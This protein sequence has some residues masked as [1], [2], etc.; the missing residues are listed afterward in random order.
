M[1]ELLVFIKKK[2][3]EKKVGEKS[4][5]DQLLPLK[6]CNIEHMHIP[7]SH[8]AMGLSEKSCQNQKWQKAAC[9]LFLSVS[10][11]AIKFFF[12]FCG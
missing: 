7:Q 4:L 11:I 3:K 9:Q 10:A 6:F 12:F 2:K 1:S 8:K 5:D